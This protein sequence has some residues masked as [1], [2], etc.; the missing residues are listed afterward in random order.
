[1]KYYRDFHIFTKIILTGNQKI[2]S[3]FYKIPTRIL[4]MVNTLK[5]PY[6]IIFDS[7]RLSSVFHYLSRISKTKLI[8]QIKF[9]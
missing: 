5:L 9:T 2:L 1:M 7:K 8:H 4:T 3:K 6:H